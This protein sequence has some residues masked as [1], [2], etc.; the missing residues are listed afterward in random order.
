MMGGKGKLFEGLDPSQDKHIAR[1]LHDALMQDFQ[2]AGDWV[3]NPGLKK[4]LETANTNYYKNSEFIRTLENN[5]LGKVLRPT[6]GEYKP[7]ED[8]AAS[9]VNLANGPKTN[10]GKLRAVFDLAEFQNDPSLSNGLKQQLIEGLMTAGNRGA[11]RF[12][13]GYTQYNPQSVVEA[14]VR[15]DPATVNYI[16]KDPRERQ[17]LKDLVEFNRRIGSITPRGGLNPVQEG[18]EA[19]AIAGGAATGNL[20]SLSIFGSKFVAKWYLG[21]TAAK[22]VFDPQGQQ[23]LRTLA[24]IDPTTKAWTSAAT[25]TMERTMAEPGEEKTA[26]Q[27]PELAQ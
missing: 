15:K 3:G 22:M 23:A 1:E 17:A 5:V 25:Y 20:S 24:R 4:Q 27:L 21:K 9:L 2:G 6:G 13:S 16:F 26:E 14:F 19:A 10:V 8:V 7:G 18:S 11:G 12:P